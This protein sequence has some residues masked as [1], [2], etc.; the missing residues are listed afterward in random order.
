M[1][2]FNKAWAAWPP[3]CL[4]LLAPSHAQQMLDPVVVTA[5]R[6]ETRESELLADV[7][8]IDHAE[9]DRQAGGTVVDLLGRQAGLQFARNG[10]PGTSA[11]LYMR[12]A[13]PTQTKVLVDGISINSMDASGSPLANIPLA[14]IDHIEIVRGPAS[15]LYGADAVSG[16]IQIFTRKA[17]PGVKADGF[18]GY[19][20]QSTFQSNAGLSIGQ[21]KWRLRVE[22]NRQSSN[23]ISARTHA[24]NYDADDDGY[25]NT[26]GAVSLSVLPAQ[27]QEVGFNYRHN[28]G[29]SYYDNFDGKGTY[30]THAD[31]ANTQWQFYAKNR[32]ASFWNSTLRYGEAEDKRTDYAS[33]VGTYLNTHNQQIGWQN[34][35]DLPLGRLLAAVERQ[36]Q[37]GRAD[38]SQSF[39][40]GDHIANNSV[41]LGWTASLGRHS[42]QVN[43]R[44]DDNSSFG[45]KNTYS[46][47]YGYQI[48]PS[49]RARLSYGTAFK[50]PSIYQLYTPYYG[51]PDLKAETGRNREV[52]LVWEDD[53][54]VASLTYYHNTI[55]NMIDWVMTDPVNFSGQYENVAK[56]RL[57]GVT[58]A[59]DGRFGDWRLHG[60]YDW[61]DAT[62]GDTGH[63]LARRARNK[64]VAGA[65]HFWGPLEA[66]AEVVAVGSRFN[67]ADESVRLGGY[68]LVNL[69][70]R[71]AVS[72]SLAIEGRVDNL[73]DKHYELVQGYGT[74][75]I[76]A[77]VGVRYTPQ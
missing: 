63:T 29:R 1:S 47:S 12:G 23:G 28:E 38:A 72:K 21:D 60:T 74:P 19:G 46:A 71:Y 57:Q 55:T 65:S 11:S 76:S 16:V 24:I 15:T 13:D 73:F 4:S 26:G 69:T 52:G 42:W 33:P 36:Q 77:F 58:L 10:G 41:L 22:G 2:G 66:G 44:R 39:D 27:G 61:L 17:E 59:Y 75:G 37:K 62:D 34:D 20:T 56:A 40:A 64:L 6:Q 5:T 18:V 30:N 31:F 14:S 43:G 70:A 53:R 68:S 54:Q 35:I 45:G 7:T 8:V 67:D 3:L 49:L 9:I 51:N 32:L 50:A 48:T 25:Y